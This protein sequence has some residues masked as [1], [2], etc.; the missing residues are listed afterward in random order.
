MQALSPA[1]VYPLKGRLVDPLMRASNEHIL[2]VRVPRAGG[3]P[4]CPSL[5]LLDSRKPPLPFLDSHEGPGFAGLPRYLFAAFDEI[6]WFS[7]LLRQ[8]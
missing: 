6:T 4:G 3:R 7:V 5:L 2:I 1:L 8:R